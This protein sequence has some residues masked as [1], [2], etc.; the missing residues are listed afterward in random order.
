M[1]AI[2]V[3]KQKQNVMIFARARDARSEKMSAQATQR[4]SVTARFRRKTGMSS[5]QKITHV[6]PYLKVTHSLT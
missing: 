5:Q 4:S 6:L 3:G 1:L 2:S